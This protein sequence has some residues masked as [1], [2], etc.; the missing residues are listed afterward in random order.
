MANIRVSLVNENDCILLNFKKLDSA[1]SFSL[2]ASN[3]LI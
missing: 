3:R 2:V 1:R